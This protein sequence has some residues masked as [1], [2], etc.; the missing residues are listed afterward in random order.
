MVAA[1]DFIPGIS[2]FSI[3]SILCTLYYRQSLFNETEDQGLSQSMNAFWNAWQDVANNPGGVSERTTLLEKAN[4]LTENFHSLSQNLNQIKQNTN[5][6][7]GTAI[8]ELNQVT[9]KIAQLNDK[10]VSAEASQTTAAWCRAGAPTLSPGVRKRPGFRNT[11]T[12]AR[13]RG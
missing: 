1:F 5:T 9:E 2:F 6:S 12:S 4:I 13:S 7:L 8:E 10:I 3:V 11:A